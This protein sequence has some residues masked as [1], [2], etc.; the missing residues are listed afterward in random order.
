LTT[1]AD[2]VSTA[3]VRF[4]IARLD[5][6]DE[7]LRRHTDRLPPKVAERFRADVLA[8]RQIL[9]TAQR[10]LILHDLPQQHDV[11]TQAIEIL[12]SLATSY[13]DHP[14]FRDEWRMGRKARN[15][16]SGE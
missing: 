9:G 4:V 5:D 1:I 11:R 14:A 12:R 7:S 6:D 16:A 3:L 10:L 13:A 2:D 15:R 8:K